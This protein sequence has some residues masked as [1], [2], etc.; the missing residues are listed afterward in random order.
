MLPSIEPYTE[1][2]T[3]F[4]EKKKKGKRKEGKERAENRGRKDFVKLK[5]LTSGSFDVA[6]FLSYLP[7]HPFPFSPFLRSGV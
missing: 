7:P 3:N 1:L 6:S 5:L 4:F 2:S